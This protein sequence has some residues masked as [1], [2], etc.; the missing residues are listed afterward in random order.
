MYNASARLKGPIQDIDPFLIQ[1]SMDTTINGG[2]YVAQQAAVRM[3][4]QGRRL[5]G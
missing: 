3:R 2:F 4:Q 5:Y 1:S